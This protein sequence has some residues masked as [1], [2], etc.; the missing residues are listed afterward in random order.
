V[1]L[2]LNQFS[3]IQSGHTFRL[4]IDT[5]P[6]GEVRVFQAK[7]LTANSILALPAVALERHRYELQDGDVL[8][9][10]R[11]TFRAAAVELKGHRA[12][13]AS[14]VMVIR[15]TSP[16]VLPAYLALYLNSPS[17][18]I[19]LHAAATGLTVK[20]ITIPQFG[21]LNIPVPPIA[22]QTTLALLTANITA[23]QTIMNSKNK[24]LN[25]IINHAV[26][27]AGKETSK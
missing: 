18:Q 12:V 21:A 5:L 26:I 10:T 11:G 13:A 24:L 1:I 20:S 16:Q 8:V 2:K 4:S 7:D 17:G 15:I 25:D 23:Q 14:S 19:Q 22:A 9:S 27:S 6:A 3:T